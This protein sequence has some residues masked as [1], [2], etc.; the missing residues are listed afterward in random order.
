ML[1]P[2]AVMTTR[3]EN[4][5]S[6]CCALSQRFE[7]HFTAYL[8]SRLVLRHGPWMRS[9]SCGTV[10]AGVDPLM[11][12]FAKSIEAKMARIPWMPTH[13]GRYSDDDLVLRD[14][15]VGLGVGFDRA[16]HAEQVAGC[17]GFR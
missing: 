8:L 6:V 9:V 17:V 10:C 11:I 15:F 5:A 14:D 2:L 4:K 1:S 3:S 7:A 13:L 16:A 12:G